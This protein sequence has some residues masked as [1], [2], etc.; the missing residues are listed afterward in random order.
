MPN[1]DGPGSTDDTN[2]GDN[3]KETFYQVDNPSWLEASGPI[4][5]GG[6]I[7]I[8]QTP[9]SLRYH[10]RY[11]AVAGGSIT[12]L[13]QDPDW[14]ISG[15]GTNKIVEAQVYPFLAEEFYKDAKT[16]QEDLGGGSNCNF[17]NH[18]GGGNWCGDEID[19]AT[20]SA[21]S[22]Q[23][24]GSTWWFVDGPVNI[25]S[26]IITGSMFVIIA[27]G[28]ITINTNVTQ[29]NAM[30]VSDSEVRITTDGAWDS[31]AQLTINGAIYAHSVN[32]SRK[33]G[34]PAVCGAICDNSAD[35]ALVINQDLRYLVD[36]TPQLGRTKLFWQEKSP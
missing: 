10:S 9:P 11:T 35:P 30:L 25:E 4:A 19:G 23:P 6:D 27:K 2:Y 28:N 20:F 3:S 26:N 32:L 21:P 14:R 34:N 29:V 36:F 7:S 5:A 15:Y 13:V 1:C 16:N 8:S 24:T 22:V 17:S 12:G 31:G 18:L 33:L